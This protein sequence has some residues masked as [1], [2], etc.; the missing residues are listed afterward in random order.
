MC[1]QQYPWYQILLRRSGVLIIAM[2][3]FPILLFWSDRSR[4]YSYLYR[5]WCK[6]SNKPVWLA[7]SEQVGNI[8]Y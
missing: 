6:I 2:G 8:L 5:V 3:L 7:E 1:Y 4:V